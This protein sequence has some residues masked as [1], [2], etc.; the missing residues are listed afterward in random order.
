MRRLLHALRHDRR[1]TSIVDFAMI[2]PI[3]CVITFGL[4]EVGRLYFTQTLLIDAVQDA[5]RTA[6]VDQTG[7]PA[8]LRAVVEQGLAIVGTAR[9]EAVDVTGPTELPDSVRLV[10]VA[11]R[12]RFEGA[13]GLLPFGMIE[14]TAE[15]SGYLPPSP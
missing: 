10:T 15:A 8:V 13:A 6:V 14:L 12:Y 11:A 1:G 7:D 3:I 4:F 5:A 9:L 2:A